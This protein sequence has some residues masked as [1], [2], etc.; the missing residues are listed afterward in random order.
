MNKNNKG[1]IEVF[2]IIVMAVLSF[3]LIW[4]LKVDFNYSAKVLDSKNPE[5]LRRNC[6]SDWFK[7]QKLDNLPAQ[8]RQFYSQGIEITQK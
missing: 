3:L 7:N 1:F 8:C 6:L 2:L 4:L 5:E